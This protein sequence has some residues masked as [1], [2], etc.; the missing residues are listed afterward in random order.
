MTDPGAMPP[1]AID[2]EQQVIGA[3]LVSRQA[4]GA[5]A[6]VVRTPEVYYYRAHALIWSAVLHLDYRDEPADLVTVGQELQRRGQLAEV[7]GPAYLSELA[8]GAGQVANAAHHARIL[9]DLYLLRQL[10]EI[11]HGLVAGTRRP[12]AEP[13]A[14]VTQASERLYAL[15]EMGR[16]GGF[17]PVEQVLSEA[18]EAA[19]R[20]HASPGALT[21]VSTGLT[22]LDDLT[23]GW[24]ASDLIILAARPSVGKTAM[25]LG[26]GVHAALSAKVSVGIFSL[27]MSNLQVGQRLIAL[28]AQV[29]LHRLRTGRLGVDQWRQVT[30]G[31]E[32]LASAPIW[33]DDTPGLHVDEMRTRARQLKQRHG[34]GLV[35]VD[36]LQLGAS[37]ER[38][39]SREQEVSRISRGL[40][41]LAK[42]LQIPVLALS[43]L[44]RAS[45]TRGDHRPQLSDLRES[46]SLEQDS[47]VVLFLYRPKQDD[48]GA[49]EIL[50]RKH[51]NGPTGDVRVQFD[52]ETATFRDAAPYQ[53][54]PPPAVAGE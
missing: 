22:D 7:G 28:G 24:Q 10:A 50:V 25:C 35:I 17:V 49:V 32:R 23:G 36:Y 4:I 15:L 33:V 14:L 54:R 41:G 30:Q 46:G 38:G 42:E 40:K 21:G 9:R 29:N 19:S 20:A 2:I 27:E 26:A 52:A 1:Q 6:A 47:D 44:S 18:L 39:S 5:A 11:G 45:E 3:C 37:P 34:L 51:R 12:D 8:M 53:Q 13:A 43:Q 48:A 16:A 31:S